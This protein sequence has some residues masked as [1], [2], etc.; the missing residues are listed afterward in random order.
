MKKSIIFLLSAV[1]AIT[2]IGCG[3]NK[4]ADKEPNKDSSYESALDVLNTVA[5][6][7]AEDE[8]FPMSGGDSENLSTEGP[9][10][11]NVSKT[12]ELDTVLGLPKEESSH[13]DDA[14]SLVHMMNSNIFTGAAYHLTKDTDMEEFSKAVKEHVLSRQ[15][16][17]GMPDTL[18]ILKV[19][20]EYVITA[21]G[22]DELI[23]T[24]KEN[25]DSSL[26]D[27]QVLLETSVTE[28]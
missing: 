23:E 10:A 18:V 22:A 28:P 8:K 14:A 21:F 27:S 20:N 11:F 7:Y 3:K 1:M 25:A 5:E 17:C 24:F 13:I 2:M 9:A 19:D 15:W 16:I 6:A 26:E 12:D 4:G